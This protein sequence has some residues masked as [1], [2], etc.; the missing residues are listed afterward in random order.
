MELRLLGPIEVAADG[1][2]VSL[3]GRQRRTL[4]AILAVHAGQ[5]VTTDRLIDE[6]WG[7]TPPQTARKTVQAHIAHLRRALN[8]FQ[9][10][11]VSA[12]EGYSLQVDRI[13]FDV[14]H[15]E[16]L[17]VEARS[18]RKVDPTTSLGTLGQALSLF[19]GPPLV[20]A[21]DDAFSLRVEAARLDELRLG[22]IEDRL[23]TLLA[24][25]D[26]STVASEADRLVAQHPLRE[27]IWG[28]LMVALFQSGRQAEALRAFARARELLADELGIEPSQGLRD[29][30]QRI[31]E[32]DPTLNAIS[33]VGAVERHETPITRNPFKGL[34]PFEEADAADF[35]GREDLVRRLEERLESRSAVPLVV[36][37][38]PSGA[39]KSSAVRAG[40]VPR[41]RDRGVAVGLM[42]PGADPFGALASV[43]A[44]VTD[45][46]SDRV[47]AAIR[48]KTPIDSPLVIV[49]DQL[50]ELFTMTSNVDVANDF[51]D[52][53]IE[54]TQPIR[55]VVTV[56]A[57]FLDPVMTHPRFGSQLEASL[58]LVP[59]FHEDEV[60]A[61]VIG[62]LQRVGVG[63]EPQL[64]A[65]VLSDVRDRPASLPLLQYALTD[66]FERRSDEVLRLA[67]YQRAGGI[68]GALARRAEGSWASLGP[69]TQGVARLLFLQ[70]VTV[71]DEGEVAKKRVERNSLVGDEETLDTI[72]ERFGGQRLLTFDQHLESGQ[73]TVEMA[74]EAL[75]SEWPRFRQWIDAASDD[76]MMARRLS[77]AVSEWEGSDRDPSFLL[78]GARLAGMEAWSESAGLEISGEGI[79]LIEQSRDAEDAEQRAAQK[80][81]RSFATSLSVAAVVAV[82]MAIFAFNQAGAARDQAAVA[83]E[84]ARIASVRQLA[85]YS[86][87]NLSTDPE[88]ATLLALEAVDQGGSVGVPEAEE[89]LHRAVLA[90]RLMARVPNGHNGIAHFSPTGDAFVT[91]SEDVTKAQVWSVDPVEERLTL[92]G[93]E[94]VVLDAVYSKDGTRMATTSV[95]GTVR[96]WDSR[97]GESEIVFEVPGAEPLIPVF[98][99][100]GSR[101]AASSFD[102]VV[103]VWDLE[104]EDLIWELSPPDG[105]TQTLNLEFSPDGS[106]LAVAPSEQGGDGPYGAHVWDMT[107]GALVANLADH[108]LAVKDV[109]FTPDGSR[110][111]TGSFD[112]T[113]KEYDTESWELLRTFYGAGDS[114]LDLQISA[115]GTVVAI[116]GTQMALV[117]DLATF[118]VTDSLSGHVGIVDG[119]DLSPDGRLLLTGGAHDGSTRLWDIS[120]EAS[121]ELL[122]LPGAD[123]TLSAGVAFS[124]DGNRLGASR[125]GGSVTI[126]DFPSGR[127][128]RTLE[129]L[130]DIVDVVE[131]D[132]TG[133]YLVAAG[134]SGMTLFDTDG[135]T[136][137]QLSETR[138]WHAAFSPDGQSLV[139]ITDNGAF[140]WSLS[141]PGEPE[142]LSPARVAPDTTGDGGRVGYATAFHPDGELVALSL[143]DGEF[144]IVEVL[145]L[146]T[147]Q[148][149]A[150]ITEHDG[151]VWRMEFSPDG[152]W[153]ATAS[154][155]TTAAIWDTDD[156][157][158]AHT[159]VGHFDHVQTV[160][161]D[162]VRPE[163]ATSGPDEATKIWSLDTGEELLSL[164]GLYS[165]LAYSPD[166]SYIAGVGPESSLIVYIRDV[167][168]LA[169]EAE[170][171]LTRWW[172]EDEC[173][174]YLGSETC[175]EA[176]DHL[177]TK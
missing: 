147:G 99:W 108:S 169:T 32:H 122:A 22:A 124:P 156:F 52:H 58:V 158:L 59:P 110:L 9:D 137:A 3:G 160:A 49:V 7:D 162:P 128:V 138:V 155:D 151:P 25:G 116:S 30:E 102:G 87:S 118:E 154:L 64:V 131:Y 26:A 126:W 143:D 123:R 69:T 73:A 46:S 33:A 50:E 168:E 93:H 83:E 148:P 86:N 150:E 10:V 167:D 139:A 136:L 11:L 75:I 15:F 109:G 45:Q 88:L 92:A 145:N 149:V 54:G 24:A 80:R 37:A 163:V 161:F 2:L 127:E 103:R 77:V 132:P 157:E 144:G 85:A 101:L 56:R 12:G 134:D 53:I 95:D 48:S 175:R 78:S 129:G 91:M 55:W 74:H 177:A 5:P 29:L 170:R 146:A 97:T 47:T 67:D 89:A 13:D 125:G 174:R 114:I 39:G 44:D 172:T 96:V 142:M 17:L 66:T 43:I 20:G 27:R 106:L 70:L 6:L 23:D 62:P 36:L 28:L 4:L 63:V 176:P 121:Y 140:L 35:F 38:G 76:L 159:L 79:Q 19:R 84:Q 72:L 16:H 51:L 113:V 81:R 171:R 152:R 120:D 117:F 57:D 90:D 173:R 130:G 133:R 119:V 14:R 68:S 141:S 164:D 60:R 18:Q 40:L 112:T 94:D 21:A 1:R 34:R 98:S 61:V 31:L 8:G 42:F 71:S 105:T 107:T 111:L 135:V 115:D 100:D 153:L 166:G 104:S 65:A 82:G 165:D 41:L